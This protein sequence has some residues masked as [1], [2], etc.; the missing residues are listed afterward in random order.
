MQY[1]M[2]KKRHYE[3]K[4]T[5][6]AVLIREKT[7]PDEGDYYD[8]DEMEEEQQEDAA[9][10]EKRNFRGLNTKVAVRIAIIVVLLVGVLVFWLNRDNFSPENI[11]NW[12]QTQMMGT[13]VGDGYPVEITGSDVKAGNFAVS[14]GNCIVLSDTA[15]T[16]LNSTGR[17][18]FS[19]R[20]SYASPGLSINN[21]R[22]L[23]YNR[24]GTNYSLVTAE[25][26]TEKRKTEEKITAAAISN[27]GEYAILTQPA[28]YAS[29][30]DVYSLN[31]DLKYYY[32]FAEGYTTALA[33]NEDGTQGAVASVN[34]SSGELNTT[35]SV[36]DFNSTEP[37]A[38]YVSQGNIITSLYWQGNT[39]Y[40]VGDMKTVVSSG[41]YEFAEYDYGGK[42]LTAV[43]CEND[44][45]FVSISG[46]E[47]A[48]PSTLLIF[49]GSAEPGV[50]EL[51]DRITDISSYGNAVSV[52]VRHRVY[53]YDLYSLQPRGECDA[54]YDTK[55]IAM[56][57][58]NDLYVLGVREIGKVSLE[59]K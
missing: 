21:G 29:R 5:K 46:Y 8:A 57:N 16:G 23:I 42:Q 53:A 51:E 32:Q 6:E 20:H 22:Y 37:V 34:S 12:F 24:G 26:G 4:K 9:P 39:I 44:R 59:K 40:G 52:L 2:A 19:S 27:G 45:V 50:I 28:D 13:G 11:S 25:K 17:E 47:H 10:K 31:G 58:E 48:G 55:A 3:K 41:G 1:D 49:H 18:M 30:L 38:E 14:D 56:T 35:I 54:Q 36:F 43:T 7:V 33:L 15:L